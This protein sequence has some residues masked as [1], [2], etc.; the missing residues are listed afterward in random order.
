[1]VV[2]EA[3]ISVFTFTQ[4]PQRL[5]VFETCDNPKGLCVLCP[6]AKH[7]IMVLPGTEIGQVRGCSQAAL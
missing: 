5:H 1:M 4:S 2:L 3:R 6:D 7:S